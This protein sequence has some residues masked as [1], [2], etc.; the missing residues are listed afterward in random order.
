[1]KRD[2]IELLFENANNFPDHFAIVEKERKITYMQFC[3]LVKRIAFELKK[4]K[5]QPK[6]LIHLSRTIETYAT[7]FASL[8]VGGF[9]CPTSLSAPQNRQKKIIQLFN[10]DV[11]VTNSKTIDY[12]LDT[13][14]KIINIKSISNNQLKDICP[15]HD[16]QPPPSFFNRFIW[17]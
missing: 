2:P 6:I 12:S 14:P 7:M 13:N 15:S 5:K 16:L 8:Q 1:M 4:V 10:P 3:N 9:Y 17:G 11:I